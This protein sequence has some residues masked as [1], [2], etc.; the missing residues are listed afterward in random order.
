MK[1][2]IKNKPIHKMG[3]SELIRIDTSKMNRGELQN[4]MAQ[5][6]SHRVI[7]KRNLADLDESIRKTAIKLSKASI[8]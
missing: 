7:V 6:N 4:Y 3:I 8:Q 5:L 2:N 1:R